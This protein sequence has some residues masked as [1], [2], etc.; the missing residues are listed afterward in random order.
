MT[1]NDVKDDP[2]F[3]E[4]E[5]FNRALC[6]KQEKKN[7]LSLYPTFISLF[8]AFLRGNNEY[9]EKL[10]SEEAHELFHSGLDLLT[11]EYAEKN[12]QEALLPRI[13]S[14][15]K[16]GIGLLK[17]ML[18][19]SIPL[20]LFRY[21]EHLNSDTLMNYAHIRDDFWED[22]TSFMGDQLEAALEEMRNRYI[23]EDFEYLK[24]KM[25]EKKGKGEFRELLELDDE[26]IEIIV[27]YIDAED[28]NEILDNMT[29]LLVGGDERLTNHLL[30]NLNDRFLYDILLRWIYEFDQSSIS[31]RFS[32][33]RSLYMR[34]MEEL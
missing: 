8:D 29:I 21:K 33:V 9:I 25:R 13:Y 1:Y 24:S 4:Y 16:T 10:R 26:Q 3:F 11:Q 34:K 5:L 14:S 28:F 31:E 22:I 15:T 12:L 6:S 23:D 30:K 2:I 19:A 27:F 18:Y 20:L 7:L 32:H 17:D